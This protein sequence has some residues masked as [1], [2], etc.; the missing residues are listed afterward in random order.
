MDPSGTKCTPE[1]VNIFV[2]AFKQ[3]MSITQACTLAGVDRQTYYNWTK[4]GEAGEEPYSSFSTAIKGATAY[5]ESSMLEI[6]HAH[7]VDKWQAAAWVLERRLPEEWSRTSKH[8]LTGKDGG[9]VT[10]QSLAVDPRDLDADTLRALAKARQKR[11]AAP[12][13]D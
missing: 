10:V 7:A 11:L 12:S 9:P 8:E 5:L 2:E 4:R 1:R 6:I 3:G 13:D